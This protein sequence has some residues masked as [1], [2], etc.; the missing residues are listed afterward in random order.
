MVPSKLLL[1]KFE[2]PSNGSRT[3]EYSPAFASA[4]SSISSDATLLT[5]PLLKSFLVKRSFDQTS[6]CNCFSPYGLMPPANSSSLGIIS[7]TRLDRSA[8]SEISLLSLL[9]SVPMTSLSVLPFIRLTTLTSLFVLTH[10]NSLMTSEKPVHAG[11]AFPLLS[12]SPKWFSW[13]GKDLHAVSMYRH[14]PIPVTLSSPCAPLHASETYFAWLSAEYPKGDGPLGYPVSE[15][16]T[17]LLSF[18]A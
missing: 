12:N 4:T 9:S 16:I 5:R 7:R 18:F 11:F 15:I 17:G 8:I 10:F 1:F 13:G 2:E 6:I 3:I 14:I